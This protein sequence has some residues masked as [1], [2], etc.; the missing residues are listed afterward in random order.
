MQQETIRV[1]L[2][3]DNISGKD[4]VVQ[5]LSDPRELRNLTDIMNGLREEAGGNGYYK[6]EPNL[7]NFDGKAV[8]KATITKIVTKVDDTTSKTTVNRVQFTVKDIVV[9]DD[10]QADNEN[11]AQV[12]PVYEIIAGKGFGKNKERVIFIHV[13]DA[14]FFTKKDLKE[15]VQTICFEKFGELSIMK[16]NSSESFKNFYHVKI[17]IQGQNLQVTDIIPERQKPVDGIYKVS[18][19]KKE[20]S[21]DLNFLKSSIGSMLKDVDITKI[22]EQVTRKK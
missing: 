16:I 7:H 12:Q 19:K 1:Y 18:S 13:N 2:A 10:F 8:T 9:I 11:P 14:K 5:H 21:G 22:H 3:K 17:T 6:W 15:K 4:V 20:T